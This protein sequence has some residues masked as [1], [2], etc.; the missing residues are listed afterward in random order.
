MAAFVALIGLA[1]GAQ[2]IDQA[3][4]KKWWK[5]PERQRMPVIAHDGS[6]GVVRVANIIWTVRDVWPPN[7]TTDMVLPFRRQME[8]SDKYEIPRTIVF[9]WDTLENPTLMGIAREH[10]SFKTTYGV[11]YE[12]YEPMVKA[13]GREWSP[14][15]PEHKGW[16]WDWHID[17]GLPMAYSQSDR[18]KLAD[19]MMEKFKG[20]FGYYPKVVAAWMLDSYSVDYLQ[21]KY[22]V[23]AF[24]HCREQDCIDSYGL[25]GGYFCGAY[26][27]SKKNILSAAV[28]MENAI[29][30][31][32][33]RMYTTCPIY[34]YGRMYEEFARVG[35][36]GTLEP[37]WITGYSPICANWFLDMFFEQKG[38]LNF[39]HIITGQ[40][41]NWGWSAES[42][43]VENVCREISRRWRQGEFELETLDETARKFKARF[44]KGNVPQTQICLEDWTGL[45]RQSVWYNCRF[46]RVNVF[47][48]GNRVILRDFHLMDDAYAEK[49]Y[50]KPCTRWNAEYFTLPVFDSY[51]Y[52]DRDTSFGRRENEG[53]PILSGNY[54][55]IVVAAQGTD[56]IRLAAQRADG[57]EATITLGEGTVEISG[58]SLEYHQATKPPDAFSWKQKGEGLSFDYEGFG[59]SVK[60]S[61]C[62]SDVTKTSWKLAPKNGTILFDYR[63]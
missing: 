59:Y 10:A 21:R 25:R 55:N 8:I 27:P 13:I 9:S 24:L 29:P 41:N 6:D 16:E 19:L 39:S 54:T 61:G 63:K 53:A 23:E 33:F 1:V 12:L 43:G 3:G 17:P 30:A 50:E 48:D 56:W 40:E 22:A 46:G 35:W 32:T 60:V 36:C 11:W 31:P 47:K 57:S 44:P 5:L 49:Y 18:E 2:E 7:R 52:G 42:N 37:V 62:F 15:D 28:E 38:L 45:G 14:K 51:M 26:Y 58:A 4:F 20:V 34:T